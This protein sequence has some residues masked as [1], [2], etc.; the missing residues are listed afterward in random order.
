MATLK[1]NTEEN[2][3]NYTTI[4][5][6]FSIQLQGN[7]YALIENSEDEGVL[8]F[9]F[10][11]EG[12]QNIL[13]KDNSIGL[14]II[15]GIEDGKLVLIVVPY[16]ASENDEPG[17]ELFAAGTTLMEAYC[18]PQPPTRAKNTA[19]AKIIYS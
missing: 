2:D 13:N 19:L 6:D 15:P 9:D 11:K 12:I 18:C 17:D 8:H 3:K 4:I 7:P 1:L 16:Q 14:R 5:R 10:T